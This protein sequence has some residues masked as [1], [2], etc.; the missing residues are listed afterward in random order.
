M[1]TPDGKYLFF[2]RYFGKFGKD[3]GASGDGEVYWV[4]I[5]ILD[6]FRP[7]GAHGRAK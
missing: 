4:D 2:S 6:Q 5:R 7:K 3:W 1:I